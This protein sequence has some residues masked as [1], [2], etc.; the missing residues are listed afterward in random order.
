M[1]RRCLICK[2]EL[3]EDNKGFLCRYHKDLA[4]EKI[5]EGGQKALAVGAA[6]AALGK[7][8]YDHR[9]EV[10]VIVKNGVEVVKDAIKNNM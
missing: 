7:A 8:A 10:V 9:E 1:T 2:K 3:A 4:K 5:N 6:V